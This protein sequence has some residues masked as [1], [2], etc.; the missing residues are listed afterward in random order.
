MQANYIFYQQMAKECQC[1]KLERIE[2]P[3]FEPS[4]K[5]YKAATINEAEE[6]MSVLSDRSIQLTPEVDNVIFFWEYLFMIYFRS[7]KVLYVN[8]APQNTY[9]AC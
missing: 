6:T 4:I 2:F 8:R 3:I 5:E 1:S 7:K 9:L